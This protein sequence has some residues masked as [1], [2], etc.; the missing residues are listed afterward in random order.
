MCTIQP[1]I[2]LVGAGP[3]DPELITLK[4]IKALE[5]ASVVLY[6]T[7]VNESLLEH[8]PAAVKV[9][10][11]KIPGQHSMQQKE[12]N[13]A[14]VDYARRMG[15]VVR[16]K[17]GDPFVFG[18]ATEEIDAIIEAGIPFSV[19]PGIS[20]AIAVA[21]TELI[22]LTARGTNESFWVITGTKED[23]SLAKD[24]TLAAQSTATLVIL[25]GMHKL[26]TIMELL[27]NQQR[28]ETEVA[29]IHNGTLPGKKII[30]GKVADIADK[31]CKAGFGNPAI[32]VI[33][34]VVGIGKR[35]RSFAA[36]LQ[37]SLQYY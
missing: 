18:R 30:M 24:I 14:L 31:A 13:T 9:Y 23:R 26:R 3:G 11:G 29:I 5:S 2:S 28:G 15:H 7:L 34:E 35:F 21:E 27:V 22:P 1:Y 12:I 36:G 25:M 8:A 33:G 32:I 19:I 10:A 6:D 37:Q 17:G 16:L 4:A 20:S